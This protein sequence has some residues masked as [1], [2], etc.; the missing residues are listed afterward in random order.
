MY[1]IF[2]LIATSVSKLVHS[3]NAISKLHPRLDLI[4]PAIPTQE[5]STPIMPYDADNGS[6]EIWETMDANKSS[7]GSGVIVR[8]ELIDEVISA[9]S[10]EQFGAVIEAGGICGIHGLVVDLLVYVSFPCSF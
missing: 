6:P 5:R 7:R 3:H 8:R 10:R 2:R 4:P 1:R 9:T